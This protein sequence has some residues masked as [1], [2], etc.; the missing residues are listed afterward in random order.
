[1]PHLEQWL[2]WLK[3]LPN[4]WAYLLLGISAFV[5]NIFPPIPGDTI[6]AFGAFL[7]GTGR[8]GFWGVYAS[9]TAGS[10]VGFMALFYVGGFLGRRFFLD[11]DIRFFR[12]K[13]ILRAEE[14]FRRHGY[15]LIL[16]NRFLPGV[17]SVISIAAG[18]SRLHPLPVG[19]LALAS[20]ALWNLLWIL[21][22]RLLGASWSVARQN[23]G[24]LMGQY[25]KAALG[26]VCLV[27]AILV[28]RALWKRLKGR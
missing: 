10:L 7:V 11:R 3:T 22:G 18:I 12:A 2:L 5:E 19:G 23:M 13:D 20:A 1:M 17:R 6:T 16:L 4:E 15:L 24:R 8:L 27:A 26:L 25:Q 9:T 21:S 28:G 14:W